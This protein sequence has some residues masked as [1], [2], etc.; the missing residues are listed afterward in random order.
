VTRVIV[1]IHKK[2]G[3]PIFQGPTMDLSSI[4]MKRFAPVPLGTRTSGTGLPDVRCKTAIQDSN[5][6]KEN[7]LKLPNKVAVVTGAA[8]GIGRA[9]AE[10][11]LAEGA[12][13]V[14]ADV[15][16]I[17]SIKPRKP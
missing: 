1:A 15:I 14:I 4:S 10:R 6:P 8:R 5:E 13:V 3:G 17:A 2:R 9:S 12:K 16:P 11:L 7:I